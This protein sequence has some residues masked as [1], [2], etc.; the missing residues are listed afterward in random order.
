MFQ[1]QV[2]FDVGPLHQDDETTDQGVRPGWY[3]PMIQPLAAAYVLC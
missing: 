3:L 1:W 2:N